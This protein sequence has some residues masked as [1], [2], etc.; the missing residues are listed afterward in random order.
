MFKYPVIIFEGIE[1]SGKSTY[2]SNILKY[3]KKIN[4]K[5]VKI[6]EPGGSKYSEIIRKLILNNRSKLNFKSDF[7]M[8]MAS[9]SENMEKIL[10][11]NYGKKIIIIDRFTDSTMAYQHYGMGINLNLIKK[12]NNFLIGNFKPN[13]TFLS[14]VNKTNMKKRLKKRVL[15]NKY[16]NFSYSFYDKVQKG[17]LKISKN[18]N[19]YV[20]LDSNKKSIKEISEKIIDKIIKVI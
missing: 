4:R 7:L 9:R 16:D 18:S 11:K 2:I 10:R 15:I 12:V 20:I 19:K 6:R 17:Y 1:T 14:I 3:L 13:V 5:F 8:I